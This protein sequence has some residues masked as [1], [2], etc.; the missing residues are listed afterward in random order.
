MRQEGNGN[1]NGNGN[2][3]KVVKG[4]GRGRESEEPRKWQVEAT[5]KRKSTYRRMVR[6]INKRTVGKDARGV[7]W[8]EVHWETKEE[9]KRKNKNPDEL[10]NDMS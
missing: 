4:N 9:P 2:N 10:S 6:G 1:G 5:K 3:Q 8:G 7:W